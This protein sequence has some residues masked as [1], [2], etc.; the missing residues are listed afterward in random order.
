M[1]VSVL[2]LLLHLSPSSLC[3]LQAIQ[4]MLQGHAHFAAVVVQLQCGH[5][6]GLASAC[7]IGRFAAFRAG[8][9]ETL[10]PPVDPI[11]LFPHIQNVAFV[12]SVPSVPDDVGKGKVV[13]QEGA[14]WLSLFFV[15][16]LRDFPL[17][18][19]I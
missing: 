4:V 11:T 5:L 15:F 9:K 16:P 14:P 18:H 17:I 7:S 19:C 6:I 13:G 12:L 8:E 10:R 2:R 3:T 1:L